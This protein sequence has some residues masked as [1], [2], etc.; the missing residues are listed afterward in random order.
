[1][2][3]IFGTDG[4]ATIGLFREKRDAVEHVLE[5]AQLLEDDDYEDEVEAARQ[6]A[7]KADMS[8]FIEL[9][10]EHTGE[11][12]DPGYAMIQKAEVL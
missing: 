5:T 4:S 3:G 7:I 1:M 12:S 2:A 8:D 11:W 10:E 9:I 6:A